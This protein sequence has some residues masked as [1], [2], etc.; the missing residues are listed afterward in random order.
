MAGVLGLP[1]LSRLTPNVRMLFPH[2]VQTGHAGKRAA[3]SDKSEGQL[4]N[5]VIK[6]LL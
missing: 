5:K 2:E 4:K 6:E 3:S 1:F